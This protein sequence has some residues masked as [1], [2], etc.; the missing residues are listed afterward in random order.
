MAFCAKFS[1]C[2][3]HLRMK[4]VKPCSQG[5]TTAT[6]TGVSDIQS[7]LVSPFR[8]R[9]THWV[10]IQFLYVQLFVWL[11]KFQTSHRTTHPIWPAWWIQ[12]ARGFV[13]WVLFTKGN[14][15]TGPQCHFL[16]C[17]LP[18]K[19]VGLRVCLYLEAVV[20]ITFK[21]C[22]KWHLREGPASPTLSGEGSLLHWCQSSDLPDLSDVITGETKRPY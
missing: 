4:S 11:F 22:W 13:L 5:R 21:L 8:E 3:L 12:L 19:C 16:L 15:W 10:Y 6:F 9:T 7:S 20:R 17:H 14:W 2:W 18:V 1:S